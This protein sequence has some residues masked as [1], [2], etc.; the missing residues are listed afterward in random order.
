[1]RWRSSA[2]IHSCS[3]RASPRTSP[4]RGVGGLQSTEEIEQ[5]ARRAQ[6]TSS[7]RA[8]PRATRP[9]RRARTDALRRAAPAAGDR[10]GAARQPAGADPRR[11]HLFG[12]CLDR[13]ADQARAGRG[14]AGRT[15]FVIAHRLSTIALADEIVVLEHGR[16][17]A[18]RR[19]RGTAR[20]APSSIARS[21]PRARP[22]TDRPA[23]DGPEL[24]INA[25]SRGE[26]L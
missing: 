24:V 16:I 18:Q 10:A 6:A 26:A 15:T 13:A 5:A 1:M 23:T 9:G 21:S 20:A 22:Q 8:C 3:R 25:S 11:R 4:T 7:S 14:D 17:V 2:T 19:P 12:R